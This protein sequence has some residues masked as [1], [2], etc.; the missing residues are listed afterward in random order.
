MEIND[1]SNY[2]E[3]GFNTG[4][5]LGNFDGIHIGHQEL[6]KSMVRQSKANQLVPSV[7]LFK[8]HTR[9]VIKSQNQRLITSLEQKI[10][11][12]KKLGIKIVFLIDFDEKLMKLTGEE[13]IKNI[14]LEKANTKLIIVGFDY[15]FGYK[16]SGNSSYLIELGKKY[17]INVNVLPPVYSK[18]EIIS[19][20]SIRKLI[21]LG[22]IKEATQVLGREYSMI[23]KVIRGD[24][25]GSKLG[26]PTANIELVDNYVIPKNGVYMTNT[27]VNNKKYISATNIGYNPTFNNQNL[28]I[29]TH[30]FNFNNN[31]YGEIIEIKFIDFIRDDIKFNNVKS[32]IKQMKLDVE[33]IKSQDIYLQL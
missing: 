14:L 10:D 28:K 6:I 17:N 16:A 5:A 26:F 18:K 4:I 21:S 19:S 24:S 33:W 22:N 23:G 1:L 20:S 8:K 15:R 13:F 25:R 32:L 12:L 27:I 11:I 7:L 2:K 29:E 30:I 3:I 9:S 31:I